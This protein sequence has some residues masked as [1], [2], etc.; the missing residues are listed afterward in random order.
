MHMARRLHSFHVSDH[1]TS[2]LTRLWHF[3]SKNAQVYKI[4]MFTKFSKHSV[5]LEKSHGKEIFFSKGSSPQC[6]TLTSLELLEVL[7]SV[8]FCFDV[9]ELFLLLLF[10]LL[11]LLLDFKEEDWLIV[12]FREPC[13]VFGSFE[14][15][16][17]AG[18]GNKS[19]SL[20]ALCLD[21]L[22]NQTN[23]LIS[24]H[25][26][27]GVM[28][29]FH[30]TLPAFKTN[31]FFPIWLLEHMISAKQNKT[32]NFMRADILSGVSPH[33]GCIPSA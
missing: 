23:A 17:P 24:P 7:P 33:H 9:E 6:L 27:T 16:G 29:F 25:G 26:H 10:S 1:C 13:S 22:P 15:T 20:A 30:L 4:K 14:G 28:D 11:L 5:T 8:L 21:D 2:L 32:V 31:L 19:F 18:E 3:E 12:L